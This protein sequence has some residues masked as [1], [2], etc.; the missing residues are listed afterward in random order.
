[1]NHHTEHEGPRRTKKRLWLGGFAAAL[2]VAVAVLIFRQSSPVEG[3]VGS[4]PLFEVQQGPLLISVTESGT[5]KARE[6]EI[7]K[8]EVEGQTTILYLVEEGVVV[9]AGELLV[10]LDSTQLLERLL[11]QEIR[12]QNL[13][14]AWINSR[15]NFEIVKNQAQSDVTAA[16]LAVQFAHEDLTKYTEGDYP[17]SLK[18]AEARITLAKSDLNRAEER[19]AGSARLLDREFITP[20]DYEADRQSAEKSRLDLEL[21]EGNRALLSDFTHER[22]MTELRSNIEETE[23]ALERVQLKANANI[24]QAEASLRAAKAEF[25]QQLDRVEKLKEQID[26]TKIYAPTS[27]LVVYSTSVGGGGF[28]GGNQEPLQEGQQV[29]ERQE[30]IY[31]PTNNAVIAEVKIHEANLSK[32]RPG[33]PVRVVIDAIP[34]MELTGRISRIAPLPDSQSAWLNPDL[35]VYHTEVHIDGVAEG[36]RTGMSCRVEILIERYDNATFIPVQAV[37]QVRGEPTVFVAQNN[38]P[39]ARPVE[40]GLDNN[41]MVRI[42]SGLQPGE[43]VLLTPPLDAASVNESERDAGEGR[44]LD[45]LMDSSDGGQ[46]A[47]P[48]TTVTPAVSLEAPAAPAGSGGAPEGGAQRGEGGA[49]GEGGGRGAGFSPEQREEMRRQM[50]SMS[51][52]EQQRMR[53]QFMQQRQ[54]GGGGGEG[55]PRGEGGGRGGEG[56]PRGEGASGA[57]DATP[58]T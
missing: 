9:E 2:L 25:D 50:E 43:K 35:K 57:G 48:P 33:L 38:M 18:E 34:G 10:E 52:E 29:R 12:A 27:G 49:R 31:L 41:R 24:V 40:I 32:V 58:S 30:L 7:I 6:Q 3:T 4:L 54:Q 5:I 42:I 21:A 46:S 17:M 16:K 53:E 51:P 26:K 11:D 15:E 8:S 28:R 47:D 13:E 20:Q 45:S 55:R 19:L 44:G 39:V 1:L 22:R 36:V 56:R 37:M 14:A 23:M